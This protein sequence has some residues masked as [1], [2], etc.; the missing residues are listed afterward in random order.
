MIEFEV[1]ERKIEIHNLLLDYTGT[2]SANG[3]LIEGVRERLMELRKRLNTIE[4]LTS[5]TF[6]TAEKELEGLNLSITVIDGVAKHVKQKRI[7]ALSPEHCVAI[8]NGNN[9]ILMLKEA[10]IGIATINAD[11]CFAKLITAADIVVC[12]ILDALDMLIDTRKLIAL[13]RE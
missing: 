6:H 3:R 13:L 5:D 2:L 11:G 4:V 7:K 9:D 8:G 1:N 12:S 10:K